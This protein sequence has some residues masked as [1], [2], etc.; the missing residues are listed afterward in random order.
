M[1]LVSF[2]AQ[3]AVQDSLECKLIFGQ[4]MSGLLKLIKE[5]WLGVDNNV[6]LPDRVFNIFNS[7]RV[8]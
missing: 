4:D 2:A 8:S 7:H 1:Q 3:K 6:N 5:A